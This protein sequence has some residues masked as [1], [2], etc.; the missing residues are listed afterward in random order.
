MTWLFIDKKKLKCKKALAYHFEIAEKICVIL[1]D[2]SGGLSKNNMEL[3][4]LKSLR[5]HLMKQA[6]KH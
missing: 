5:P 1:K 6:Q 4:F 3:F 2:G